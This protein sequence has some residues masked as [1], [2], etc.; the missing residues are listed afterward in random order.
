MAAQGSVVN[1]LPAGCML[2]PADNIWNTAIDALPVDGRSAAYIQSIGPDTG[3]H[4]DFGAGLYEGRSM[5]IPF[6]TV[7]SSQPAVA[8][9]FTAAGDESDPGPYPVPE[10]APIEGEPMTDGDRH[11]LVVQAETCLLYELFNAQ[12]GADGWSADSGAVFDLR[13]NV[14]RPAGWTSADAAGLPILPGLVRYEEIATGMISHALRFTAEQTQESYVWP[15]RHEA[16]STTDPD[17]PPMG[18]RFRLKADV[19]LSAFSPANQVILRAL[20]TYGM[21]LADNGSNWFFSGTPDDRWD[22]DDL[23]ALQEGIFG[24]DFEAVDC[25]SLMIDADSGQVA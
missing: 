12:P 23:H 4:P 14:L 18:Q 3:L 11:V 20:Q 21:M 7:P 24:A 5:G 25:S 10:D 17:V 15:A 6:V 8:I 22:N 16:G 2:F 19:D 9:T 13:S 1:R